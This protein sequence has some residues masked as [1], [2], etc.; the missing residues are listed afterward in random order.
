MK[1]TYIELMG[2]KHPLCFSLSATEELV[3]EFG[4]LEVMKEQLFKGSMGQKLHAAVTV[5]DILLRAG[6][7][8]AETVGE[9]LP[10]PIKGSVA[11][12][13]DGTD[14]EAVTKI[15]AAITGDAEQTVEA[16][17]KNA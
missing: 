15:F 9:P 8:Y 3:E 13:I 10:P 4:D 14:A 1:R 2:E 6:R 5:L 17:S 7:R 11:D 16:R 12:L